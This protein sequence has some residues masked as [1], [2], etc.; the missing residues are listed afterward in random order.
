MKTYR[1]QTH[2]LHNKVLICA[3]QLG[4]VEEGFLRMEDLTAN[5]ASVSGI[6]G[7]TGKKEKNISD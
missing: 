2:L 4:G 3:A 5:E 1:K 6:K 7:T